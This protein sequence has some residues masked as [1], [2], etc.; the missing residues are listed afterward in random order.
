MASMAAPSASRSPRLPLSDATPE[1]A[2]AHAAATTLPA[3][4]SAVA[5][6]C[7]QVGAAASSTTSPT[8][9][10]AIA[11]REYE[12]YTPRPSGTAAAAASARTAVGRSRAPA[13]R[14]QSTNPI[15]ASAPSAFQ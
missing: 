13:S 2:A 12:R 8:R 1:K 5:R 10:A 11:P 15:A 6:S 9:A 4:A 7:D 3:T 14:A